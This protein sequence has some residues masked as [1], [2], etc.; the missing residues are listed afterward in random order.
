MLSSQGAGPNCKP[1]QRCAEPRFTAA[2]FAPRSSEQ[3]LLMRSYA[4]GGAD[5]TVTAVRDYWLSGSRGH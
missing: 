4:A 1:W 3:R 5:E 2:R